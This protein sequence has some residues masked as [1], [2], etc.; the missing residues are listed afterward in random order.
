MASS[1]DILKQAKKEADKLYGSM[2]NQALG[3]LSGYASELQTGQPTVEADINKAYQGMRQTAQTA[4]ET[5]LG[6][7]GTQRE[8]AQRA[9]ESAVAEA[10]RVASEQMQGLQARYGTSTGT[11]GFTGELLGRETA[12][13]I[14][15]ERG[16]LAG[17]MGTLDQATRQ[18][19]S[20][21]TNKMYDID[22][23][24]TKAIND[25][26]NALRDQLYQ[27]NLK[28]GE[29]EADKAAKRIAAIQNFATVQA[30]IQSQ[31]EQAQ[32]QI[33]ANKNTALQ[34]LDL[35]KQQMDYEYQL[36][37]KETQTIL[38]TTPGGGSINTNRY[39]MTPTQTGPGLSITS[40]GELNKGFNSSTIDAG[41]AKFYGIK[42]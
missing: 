5:A 9:S 39:L 6:T 40:T 37:N 28:K 7:I 27:I 14:A 42:G 36:K 10:R 15:T 25:A 32:M 20:D 23:A 1:S 31:K 30:Q 3:T 34:N 22:T 26:R 4:K 11:G 41:L 19:E 35:W 2:Y 29:L 17:Q 33:E 16:N 38:P 21:T 18:V 12:R 24:A 13:G 8:S